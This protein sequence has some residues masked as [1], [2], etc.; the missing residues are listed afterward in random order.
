[1]LPKDD[2]AGINVLRKESNDKSLG[3]TQVDMDA[4][5]KSDGAGS[6]PILYCTIVR[7]LYNPEWIEL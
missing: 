6:F 4:W 2:G 5:Y 1:M 3:I 7:R